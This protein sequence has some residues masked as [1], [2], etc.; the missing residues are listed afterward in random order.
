MEFDGEPL[1]AMPAK[2]FQ[3]MLEDR[4]RLN[5]CPAGATCRNHRANGTLCG[6][7]LDRRGKTR[8]NAR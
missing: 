5:M 4:L 6:Q 1:Q 8:S 7:P 2:H 3:T